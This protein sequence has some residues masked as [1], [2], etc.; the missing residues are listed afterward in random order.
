MKKAI[1]A[2]V[3][4]VVAIGSFLQWRTSRY[5]NLIR[6][7]SGRYDLPFDLVKSLIFRESWFDP[8]ASG[9]DS[10][11]GLMQVTPAVGQ[12]YARSKGV[13]GYSEDLLFDPFWNVETGCWYLRLSVDK[14][15]DR[16]DPIVYALAR[17]NA[18]ESRV[19]RWEKLVSNGGAPPRRTS[20]GSAELLE[21]DADVSGH[22]FVAQIDFPTTREYVEGIIR[23]AR[24]GRRFYWF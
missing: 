7:I 21:G 10:E 2:A 16:P 4:A 8:T 24:S 18:G 17:Y 11:R 9:K 23:R 15:A 12:E 1:A 5:D 20:P 13:S 14:Y 19:A 6:E 22:P 3:L